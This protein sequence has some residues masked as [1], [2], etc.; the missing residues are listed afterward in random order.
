MRPLIFGIRKS[1]LAKCQLDEF[2][3]YLV[4]QKWAVDYSVKTIVT[5]GDRDRTSPVDEMGLGIFTKEIEKALLRG[6]IDCAVHSLKDMPVKVERGTVL[7]CFPPRHDVRDCLVVRDGVSAENLKKLKV[8]TGSPRRTAFLKEIEST[9][10][11]LPIRGN[12]DTRLRKLDNGDYDALVLAACGLKRL[13]YE[14]RIS[15]YFDPHHFVPASGQGIICSQTRADDAELNTALKRCSSV[16][17][18]QACWAERKILEALAIGC[19]VPFG[20]YA[21]SA[22]EKFM[23]TAKGYVAQKKS[24]IFV[25]KICATVD[26]ASAVD[27]VIQQIKKDW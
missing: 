11:A 1:A 20:V 22:D 2:I 14:N 12:I 6:E 17:T 3:A 4:S 18:E 19:Q 15:R 23:V 5:Q 24:Y 25:Q 9:V 26:R 8:G 10:E 21:S 16:G 27:D 7:S 13:G